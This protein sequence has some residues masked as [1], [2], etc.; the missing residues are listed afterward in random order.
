LPEDYHK[1]TAQKAE[2]ACGWYFLEAV[3]V[4][5]VFLKKIGARRFA[6]GAL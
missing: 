5:R 2:R 3:P 6:A 1:N 4:E